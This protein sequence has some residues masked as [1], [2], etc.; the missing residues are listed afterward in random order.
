MNSS[1]RGAVLAVRGSMNAQRAS[2]DMI[3]WILDSGAQTSVSSDLTM[4]TELHE[5][6]VSELQFGN[7]TTERANVGTAHMMVMNEHTG[8]EEERFL[9]NVS[10]SKSAPYNLISRHD[11]VARQGLAEAEVPVRSR[12]VPHV[13]SASEQACAERLISQRREPYDAAAQY[14]GMDMIKTMAGQAYNFGIQSQQ[15]QFAHYECIPCVESKTKRMSYSRG[16]TPLSEAA[17][18]A[19]RRSLQCRSR[20]SCK[21]SHSQTRDPVP[22]VQDQDSLLG[23]RRRVREQ[24]DRGVLQR[25]RHRTAFDKPVQPSRERDSGARKPDCAA[26]GALN[27]ACHSPANIPVG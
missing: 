27:A 23:W 17:G 10:Y 4:F 22:E 26:P 19:V 9:E 15:Q 25:P 13:D 3:E 7:G 20:H 8:K 14:V 21:S 11:H 5:D 24:R 18:E 2:G 1:Q 16:P 12:D 6:T